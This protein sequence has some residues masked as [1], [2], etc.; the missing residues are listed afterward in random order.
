[1]KHIRAHLTL[2]DG[3]IPRVRSPRLVPYAIRDM[4]GH[5]LDRLEETGV[6]RKVNHA[7]WAAPLVPVPKKDGTLRLCGDYKVTINLDLLVD[8]YP[9][10]KPADL[11]ACLTGGV[12]FSKLDLSSAYQ[13]M[14]LDDES[15]KL[16]TVN[17]HQGL[18]EYT[19]L[20][21]GVA[22][23]PAMFQRAMD[24]ILRGIPQVIFTWTTY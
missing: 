13:Q 4:V 19:R 17:I 20:P 15:A 16:V 3:A 9:L 22:S 10:P 12:C 18:Y 11:M 23:A 24:T 21:F 7:T 5:E 1:M 8:Q 6:L 14:L 2:R